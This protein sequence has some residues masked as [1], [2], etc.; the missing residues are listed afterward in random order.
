MSKAKRVDSNQK[1][2]VQELRDLGFSVALTYQ[3]GKGF[4]D[5]VVGFN[6]L[7]NI[8]VE[9]KSKGGKLT[10]DEI[11]FHKNYKGYI[12]IAFSTEDVI[13]GIRIYIELLM[14]CLQE[15]NLENLAHNKKSE[16]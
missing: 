8:P 14:K 9:L 7:F 11:E 5:F 3:L 16:P 6:D 4:P 10:E 15:M 13:D 1:Q 2:V 12:I